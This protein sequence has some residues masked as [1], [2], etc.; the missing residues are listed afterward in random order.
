MASLPGDLVLA[1]TALPAPFAGG[2]VHTNDGDGLVADG[3]TGGTPARPSVGGLAP[4]A[5]R[6]AAAALD[7]GQ[8]AA[9]TAYGRAAH[10]VPGRTPTSRTTAG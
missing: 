7:A 9:A 10:L 8:D 1:G 3:G 4:Q 5:V 2:S 6:A